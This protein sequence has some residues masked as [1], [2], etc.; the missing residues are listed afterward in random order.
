MWEILNIFAFHGRDVVQA[1]AGLTV[2]ADFV[3]QLHIEC[4]V[5]DVNILHDVV[6]V[7]QLPFDDVFFAW[8]FPRYTGAIIA[9]A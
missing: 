6:A 2:P 3:R 5:G 4:I 8:E 9:P 1:K 7:Y